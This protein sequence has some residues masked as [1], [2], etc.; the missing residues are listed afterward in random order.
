MEFSASSQPGAQR[1]AH[2]HPHQEQSISLSRQCLGQMKILRC[3]EITYGEKNNCLAGSTDISEGCSGAPQIEKNPTGVSPA[4]FTGFLEQHPEDSITHAPANKH[5]TAS[6]PLN[7]QSQLEGA[8]EAISSDSP[9]LQARKLR[10]REGSAPP[11]L[12]QQ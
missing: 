7:A 5:G 2:F 9:T 1:Q 12:T 4:T 8:F 11:Q 6:P 10:P 3:P